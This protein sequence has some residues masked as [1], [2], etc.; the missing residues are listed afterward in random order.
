MPKQNVEIVRRVFDAV[1]R[2]DPEAALA[3]VADDFEMEWSN[4]IGPANGIY[5]GLEE[6]RELQNSFLD[7]F[8]E[9]R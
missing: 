7:A 4:S 8:D 3:V 5:R 6:V 1:G 2:G 9:V